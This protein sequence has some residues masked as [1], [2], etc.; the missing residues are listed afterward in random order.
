MSYETV[1]YIDHDGGWFE[2]HDG[3]HFYITLGESGR[4][5]PSYEIIADPAYGVAG[6]ILRGIKAKEGD[7]EIPITIKGETEAEFLTNMRAFRYATNPLRG[8]GKLRYCMADGTI[9]YL[10]CHLSDFNVVET[11]DKGGGLYW[12]AIVATFT[13]HDP[14]WYDPN[15]HEQI[16]TDPQADLSWS[17]LVTNNGDTD[18]QPIWDITGPMT[19]ILVLNEST[20]KYFY[21]NYELLNALEHLY[22]D[23]RRGE[24]AMHLNHITNVSSSRVI[25]SSLFPF[26]PGPNKISMQ[27]SQDSYIAAAG[28]RCRWVDCYGGV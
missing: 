5:S 1:H 22:I 11:A 6:N 19:D 14:F 27:M 24:W 4:W 20:G 18:S 26:V 9:R 21:I 28:V 10:N 23:T 7:I 3:D 2:L 8:T 16:W 12:R 15:E 25:G 13:T 17:Q